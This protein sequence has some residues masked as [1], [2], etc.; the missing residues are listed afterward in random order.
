MSTLTKNEEQRAVLRQV[1]IDNSTK[2][3]I[4]IWDKQHF[5]K[6]YDLSALDVHGDVYTDGISFNLLLQTFNF[7]NIRVTCFFTADFRSFEWSPDNTKVLYIAEKKLPKSEPF[8]KQ[9]SLDKK[10]K[11]KE[12]DEAIVVGFV[13]CFFKL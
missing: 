5:V 3:F 12:D 6:N 4:E 8:Y 1:T 9:K 7:S 11:E 2:Q 13:S 10:D